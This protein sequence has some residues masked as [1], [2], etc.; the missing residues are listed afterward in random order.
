MRLGM[1]RR[2]FTGLAAGAAIGL[3]Q[4]AGFAQS[5]A[6][7]GGKLTIYCGRN[8]RLVSALMPRISAAT[9]IDLD[10]RF[11][12]TAELAAQILE[13]GDKTPAGLYFC[14]DAG[15][16]GALAKANRFVSIRADLLDQVAPRFRSPDGVWIGLSGRVRVL[17]Y[18]PN[19]TDPATLPGRIIDLPDAP[20]AGPIG[21]APANAPFQS[22]VTALRVVYG[23]EGAREWLEGVIATKPI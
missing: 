4:G 13:E 23:E 3:R 22:F 21:W 10:V 6:A 5:A 2:R 1:T 16:L 19:V 8:E 18:T 17:L 9:G 12:N 14:Q 20:L 7:G 15:A 11:G